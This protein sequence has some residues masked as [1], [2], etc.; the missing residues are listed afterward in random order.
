MDRYECIY[1][2]M[3]I[4]VRHMTYVPVA[5]STENVPDNTP[6]YVPVLMPEHISFKGHDI[7]RGF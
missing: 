2:Y 4:Y 7:N 3:C 6:P 1:V 5:C